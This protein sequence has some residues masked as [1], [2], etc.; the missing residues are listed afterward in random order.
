MSVPQRLRLGVIGL[1]EGN[2]H[3]YSW[4]AII[5]GYDSDVMSECPYPAIPAYLAQR[6]F[7]QDQLAGAQVTH[8][9]TQ[10][11]AASAHI[12]RAARIPV[13]ATE[14]PQMLGQIDGLLLARD[15]AEN[16]LR[17]AA[18]FLE[19]GIPVYLDKPPAL[20]VAQLDELFK[21]ARSAE[22]VFSCSALRF[23]SELRLTAQEAIRL[24]PLR[25]VTGSVPRSWAKYAVH[26]IDPIVSFLQPGEPISA[27]AAVQGESVSVTVSWK[28]GCTG[29]VHAT[30]ESQGEIALVYAG[31]HESIKKVFVDSFASF[32]SALQC[33]L[34]GIRLGRSATP[35]THLREV[36]GLVELGMRGANSIR[37]CR[38]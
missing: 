19:A 24:G 5:N 25:R 11:P 12:A 22:Q 35:Y 18:T 8:V 6:R 14:Y 7:P 36:V 38:R 26:V 30:G 10:D 2:G 1:S 29:L 4:S 37:R 3:P 23:A 9:W 20:S 28:N 17:F 33:F 13:V 31:E 34:E 27:D 16:H 32:R 21:L 15:D